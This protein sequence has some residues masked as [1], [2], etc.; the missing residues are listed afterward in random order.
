[1]LNERHS[2][3]YYG[4][5]DL[6][7]QKFYIKEYE[8]ANMEK[9]VDFLKFLMEQNPLAKQI[10]TIWDGATF[11]TGNLVKEFLDSVNKGLEESE[12]KIRC[13]LFAPNAP[14]QNPV[15]DCWLKAKNYIRQHILD[16]KSFKDVS[17]CFK[18]SFDILSFDFGKLNW[19]F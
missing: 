15:E 17:Q 14:D 13:L 7:T 5:L 18:M 9:T 3:T 1:M 11:H 8:W 2:K 10:I 12:W 6:M 19:Y 16:N 4:A